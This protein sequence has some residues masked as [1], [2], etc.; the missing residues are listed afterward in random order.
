MVSEAYLW[1]VPRQMVAHRIDNLIFVIL[2]F[3]HA[4]L[5]LQVSNATVMRVDNVGH[6]HRILLL[7]LLHPHLQHIRLLFKPRWV[8][9]LADEVATLSSKFIQLFMATGLR[10]PSA[11]GSA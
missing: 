6:D 7:L 8:E 1:P 2:P 5:F 10:A 4:Q 11:L 9:L 3:G